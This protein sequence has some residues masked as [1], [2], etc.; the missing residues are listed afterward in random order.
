MRVFPD[1]QKA[2]N[3]NLNYWP[4]LYWVVGNLVN[5]G[6]GWSAPIQVTFCPVDS[7]CPLNWGIRHQRSLSTSLVPKGDYHLHSQP[8]EII[9]PKRGLSPLTILGN[10]HPLERIIS[11]H[12]PGGLSPPGEDYHLSPCRFGFLHQYVEKSDLLSIFGVLRPFPL[13][14]TII[15]V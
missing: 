5:M 1:G 10:Y 4:Y 2:R 9:T 11:S 7:C 8:W 3:T 14:P 12:F 15:L 13:F 6:L